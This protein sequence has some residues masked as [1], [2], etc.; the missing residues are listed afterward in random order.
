MGYTNFAQ[1]AFTDPGAE[2][3]GSPS[4]MARGP[5]F[6]HFC[7]RGFATSSNGSST[8]LNTIT[9]PAGSYSFVLELH[10]TG[11]GSPNGFAYWLGGGWCSASTITIPTPLEQPGNEMTL[12]I[13]VTG[14]NL[15]IYGAGITGDYNLFTDLYLGA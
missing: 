14:L 11:Y 10:A 15:A 8:L 9:M 12:Q 13:V 5:T 2:W 4:I 1:P 3:S 6:N 7:S